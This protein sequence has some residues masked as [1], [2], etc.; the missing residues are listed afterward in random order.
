MK[1]IDNAM[2]PAKKGSTRVRTGLAVCS[3]RKFT[4]LLLQHVSSRQAAACSWSF[5]RI[6]LFRFS[7]MNSRTLSS[8]RV[9]SVSILPGAARAILASMPGYGAR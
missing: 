9:S 5:L 8:S 1:A 7:L 4:T 2:P 3:G 6:H